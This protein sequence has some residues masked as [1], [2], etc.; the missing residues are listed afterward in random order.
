MHGF[1]WQRVNNLDNEGLLTPC[2]IITHFDASK[3][4]AFENILGKEEIACNVFPTMFSTQSDNCIP[5][6]PYF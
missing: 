2:S 1:V 5:I 6:C 3:Q 4:A